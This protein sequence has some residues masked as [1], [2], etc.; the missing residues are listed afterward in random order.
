MPAGHLVSGGIGKELSW[1]KMIN[2]RGDEVGK[3]ATLRVKC[4]KLFSVRSQ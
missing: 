1:N 2:L 3:D 4:E